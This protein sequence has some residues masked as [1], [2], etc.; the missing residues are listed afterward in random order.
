[1]DK[2][3]IFASIASDSPAGITS[4]LASLAKHLIA[5]AKSGIDTPAE[6]KNVEDAVLS[7]FDNY[8]AGFLPSPMRQP[9]RD[10]LLTMVD[11]TLV[12]AASI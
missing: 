7:Y 8:V 9:F 3:P 12:A 10:S 11:A 6:R 4:F 2:H 5:Y 1:M